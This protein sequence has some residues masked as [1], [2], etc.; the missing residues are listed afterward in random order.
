MFS[1]AQAKRVIGDV[2]FDVGEKIFVCRDI[3]SRF[4]ALPLNYE[5]AVGANIGKGADRAFLGLDLTIAPDSDPLATGDQNDAG[6]KQG[7]D[8]FHWKHPSCYYDATSGG[9]G[10][11]KFLR[12]VAGGA[13]TPNAFAERGYSSLHNL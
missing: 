10:F 5:R 4:A 6:E 1:R 9:F 11:K 3:K 2:T 12:L 13:L 8:L 7:D